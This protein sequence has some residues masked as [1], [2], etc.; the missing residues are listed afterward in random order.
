MRIIRQISINFNFNLL[1][2]ARL[3]RKIPGGVGLADVILSDFVGFRQEVEGIAGESVNGV[4]EENC[5]CDRSS[6]ARS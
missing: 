1:T 5:R 4:G 2:D 6:V 3:K